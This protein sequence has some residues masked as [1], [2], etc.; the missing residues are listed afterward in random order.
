VSA[1]IKWGPSLATLGTPV[2]SGDSPAFNTAFTDMAFGN[3]R[4][5][6]TAD[7]FTF[8]HDAAR[9][10]VG[11]TVKSVRVPLTVPPFTFTDD[12]SVELTAHINVTK[13]PEGSLT[14]AMGS[15]SPVLYIRPWNDNYSDSKAPPAPF[16]YQSVSLTRLVTNGDPAGQPPDFDLS[17]LMSRADA[18]R[19]LTGPNPGFIFDYTP[20]LSMVDYDFPAIAF[21]V[22]QIA[23]RTLDAAGGAAPSADVFY[24]D[25]ADQKFK[26]LTTLMVNGFPAAPGGLDPATAKIEWGKDSLLVPD[27]SKAAFV[28]DG[29][30]PA[31]AN[32]RAVPQAD[33]FQFVW[34]AF[35]ATHQW[36]D[37]WVVTPAG[38]P[39]KF[40]GVVKVPVTVQHPVPDDT[41][42]FASAAYV[43]ESVTTTWSYSVSIADDGALTPAPIAVAS[44]TAS[45]PLMT[46]ADSTWASIRARLRATTPL[47]LEFVV[48]S[49][50]GGMGAVGMP[51][52]TL[53]SG[54]AMN[55]NGMNPLQGVQTTV[56]GYAA[57][58]TTYSGL[59]LVTQEIVAP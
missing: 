41:R 24:R 37:G 43:V 44:K 39:V 23:V 18:E 2:M 38:T 5:T 42:A 6:P 9:G 16:S 4:I 29:P 58:S 47:H 32:P 56:L 35:Q 34:D 15:V 8:E 49:M 19:L 25:P 20:G 28:V 7:G 40:G 13:R 33:G 51:P 3:P 55:P 1:D 48:P 31:G 21:T 27:W 50:G 53:V 59:R 57:G 11:N 45:P 54:P 10:P 22:S 30:W 36:T 17:W 52:G 46:R 12:R 26:P 14:F